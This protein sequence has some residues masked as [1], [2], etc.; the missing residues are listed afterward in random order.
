[1]S[2]E[3]LRRFHPLQILEAHPELIEAIS[4]IVLVGVAEK[5]IEP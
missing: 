3:A 2:S 1:V 4:Q 5:E